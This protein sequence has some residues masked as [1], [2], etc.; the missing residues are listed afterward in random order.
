MLQKLHD[1]KQLQEKS[2]GPIDCK[3]NNIGSC[4]HLFYQWNY[5]ASVVFLNGNRT[6]VYQ[7]IRIKIVQDMKVLK[8]F[9]F[10]N[11]WRARKRL[12]M[13]GG[14]AIIGRLNLSR[15]NMGESSV[16]M[17]KVAGIIQ[18]TMMNLPVVCPFI[19]EWFYPVPTEPIRIR[20]GVCKCT[21]Y[22]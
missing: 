10:A 15:W 2:H 19:L 11:D 3:S 18:Y 22:V 20:M 6:T 5:I 17:V 4:N 9:L 12:I 1:N 21:S 7:C 16:V 14:W 8:S 13:S